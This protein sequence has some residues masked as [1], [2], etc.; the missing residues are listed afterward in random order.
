MPIMLVLATQLFLDWYFM[1]YLVGEEPPA[2]VGDLWSED[3]FGIDPW[4]RLVETNI[5]VEECVNALGTVLG[6]VPSLPTDWDS[7]T[8]FDWPS[9]HYAWVELEAEVLP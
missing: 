6:E 7:S 5:T 9:I 4:E 1:T 8:A 2:L 3:W